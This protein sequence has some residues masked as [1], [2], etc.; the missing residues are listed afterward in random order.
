MSKSNKGLLRQYDDAVTTFKIERMSM[1]PGSPEYAQL[2]ADTRRR[3]DELR[4]Q[5]ADLSKGRR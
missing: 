4:R 5:Q 1:K 2:K 3:V